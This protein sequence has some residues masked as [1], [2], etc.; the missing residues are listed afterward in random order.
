MKIKITGIG[1]YI[2]EKKISN[3]DFGEHIFLNEDGTAFGYPN[4]VVINKFKGITGIEHRRYAEN[5]H[6]SSDL[7]F[8]A[9]Q[10]AIEN[11]GI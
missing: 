8:F 11:A 5:Q 6:T 9:A 4:E 2:P 3:T 7:A 1:S 10:K